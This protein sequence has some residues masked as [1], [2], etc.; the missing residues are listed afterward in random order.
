MQIN[1]MA[2][3]VTGGGSG[4]GADVARHLTALGAKVAVLDVNTAGVESVAQEI[5]GIACTC[6]ISKADSAE[7]AL[8]KAKAAHGPARILVN[9]AGILIPGRILGK[10]GPLPLEKFSK[11]IEVNLIGTFNM[12]RLAAADMAGMEPLADNERGVIINTSSV[13]AYEGQIGQAA[14]AASKA[15]IVGLTLP[16]ARDLA[17][18][19]IRVNAIAPGL[20]ATPMMLNLPPDIQKALGDSVPFPQRL[21]EAREFSRLVAHMIENVMLNGEVVRLDGALRLAPK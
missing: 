11:V 6:D 8:A 13:A 4:M 3:V 17:R 7:A 16:A 15:G 5:G 2:A 14:Y 9:V 20:V 18:S 1:G 12:M 10:D 19:G 21:A